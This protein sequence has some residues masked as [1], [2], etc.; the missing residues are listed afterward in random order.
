VFDEY[1]R[2]CMAGLEAL[3]IQAERMRQ[4]MTPSPN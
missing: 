1:Y 2:I 3:E 4:R